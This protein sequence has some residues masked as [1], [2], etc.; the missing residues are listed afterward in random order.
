MI[1]SSAP[2]RA[3]LLG[4][5]TDGYGGTVI[6]H[7]LAERAT[8]T[9]TPAESTL[10][11]VCGHRETIRS[12]EDLQLNG[13]HTDVA[14]AVLTM[15][16]SA[17]LERPFHLQA[18]TSVPMQAGLAGSTAMITAILGAVLRL[19]EI[20]LNRYQIAETTRKIE[21]ET[22][23]VTCGFQ[24]QYMAAFGGLNCMDFRGKD[25][26]STHEEPVFAMVEPL[27]P[28]V[29]ELPIVLANT[30]VQHHSGSVHHGL[31]SR[32]MNGDEPVVSGYLRI[33]E[34]AREGKKALLNGDWEC[35]GQAM[36][37]NHAIQRSLGGSGEANEHLIAAA[38]AA[39]AWGAKL[40][41]AGHGGTIL[42]LHPD[43]EYVAQKLEKAGAAR[44][45]RV[46]PSDG[47]VVESEY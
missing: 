44:T 33:T 26:F 22:M 45:L 9:M 16:E 14:K 5:P 41:G 40:A 19:L 3:G 42:A 37:E 11:D 13:C 32:W 21:F 15:F 34:L 1:H 25:P 31:R 2:G 30:G 18:T 4:N 47:L 23:R 20:D 27:A 24:D 28:F 7:S 12:P 17:V 6:S 39:G 10:L 8:V 29:G 36:N 35:L 43:P 38:L 46:R